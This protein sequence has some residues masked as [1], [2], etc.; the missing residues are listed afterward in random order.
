VVALFNRTAYNYSSSLPLSSEAKR[1]QFI[2]VQ[3]TDAAVVPALRAHNPRLKILM[4]QDVQQSASFD[5]NAWTNCTSYQQDLSHHPEW[6][7]TDQAGRRIANVHYPGTYVMDVGNDAYRAACLQHVVAVA[8]QDGFDG[9]VLD[10]VNAWIGWT[11]GSGISS[12]RY[13]SFAAWQAVMSKLVAEAGPAAHSQGLLV[14]ANIGGAATTPGVWQRWVSQ[15]DGAEEESW[16][17]NGVSLADSIYYWRANLDNVAWSEAH[18]KYTLL[19][20]YATT[21][22][23]NTYGL[24]SMLLA[25]RGRSGYET[26]NVIGSSAEAWYPEYG[27]ARRLGPPTGPYKRLRRG[28][29]MRRFRRGLVVVNP[30]AHSTGA[31][32]LGG[33]RY[34]GSGLSR[35]SSVFLG[36]TTGLILLR[37]R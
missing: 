35:V 13:P 7:L 29:Y 11:F 2:V 36:P 9:V 32:R 19:H 20:S 24:A 3:S 30:T 14:F 25:A 8:R 12:P 34:S 31:I 6:F 22:G 18:R 23:G 27:T 4:Y 28:A 5:P 26:S 10:D 1:Y 33:G 16:T 17:H 21:E 15:L 37:S